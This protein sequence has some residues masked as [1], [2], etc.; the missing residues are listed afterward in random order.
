MKTKILCLLLSILF[1]LPVL[2]SAQNNNSKNA[3]EKQAS[4][5]PE[6]DNEQLEED[7]LFHESLKGKTPQ[8]RTTAIRV[9]R[10]E[11]RERKEKSKGRFYQDN[12]KFLE[13]KLKDNTNLSDLQKKELAVFFANQHDENIS[14]K[15]KQYIEEVD[16][17]IQITNSATLPQAQKKTLIKS[18]L[19]S[20]KVTTKQDSNPQYPEGLPGENVMPQD[21]NNTQHNPLNG[22]H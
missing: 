12:V 8:E 5:V 1:F 20:K 18:Y 16:F 17:F 6:Y 7:V 4:K 9:Y 11:Q 10:Q 2:I 22:V 21:V 3:S 19:E 14:L 13:E 15:N